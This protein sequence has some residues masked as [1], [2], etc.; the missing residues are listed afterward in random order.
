MIILDGAIE[1]FL[2]KKNQFQNSPIIAEGLH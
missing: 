2:D 1:K